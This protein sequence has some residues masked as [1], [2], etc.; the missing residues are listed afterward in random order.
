MQY[1]VYYAYSIS[2]AIYGMYIDAFNLYLL[3]P[4]ISCEILPMITQH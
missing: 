2:S 3:D 1:V 4:G